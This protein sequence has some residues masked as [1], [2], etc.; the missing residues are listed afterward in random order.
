M[1]PGLKLSDTAMLI[2]VYIQSH[3]KDDIQLR[4]IQ[5]AMGFASPSSALFHLQK[6]EAAGL[7]LK[8]PL[9]NYRVKTRI[10]VGLVRNFVIIR[11]VF[12]PRHLLYAS[13][14]TVA[15][16][17]YF[18]LLVEFLSTPIA[19]VAL[20]LNAASAGLFWYETWQDWK[21]KPRFPGH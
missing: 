1:G 5:H 15:L 17:L 16:I 8:E 19:V 6:L 14:M 12:V 20:L 9:G 4:E 7:I 21:I 2:Y 3:S 13:V 11:G 18:T 10:R